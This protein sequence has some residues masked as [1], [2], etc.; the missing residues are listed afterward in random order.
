MDKS[1]VPRFL[2]H[3]VYVQGVPKITQLV[4][5]KTSSNPYQL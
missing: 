4:F 5:V 3:P 2:A 1:K